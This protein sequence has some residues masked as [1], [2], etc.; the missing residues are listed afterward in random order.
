MTKNSD[1]NASS[2]F[3]RPNKKVDNANK[4]SKQTLDDSIHANKNWADSTELEFYHNRLENDGPKLDQIMNKLE[5]ITTQL[6]T[7]HT[8][9]SFT[10]ERVNTIEENLGIT[11]L[12]QTEADDLNASPLMTDDEYQ[13]SDPYKAGIISD[14]TEVDRLRD[15]NETLRENLE[16]N[17]KK[18]NYA[19]QAVAQMQRALK[20]TNVITD[21]I[22]VEA[23][24][25]PSTNCR[26]DDN[27]FVSPPPH[28]F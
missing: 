23:L 19:L 15:E 6:T 3:H 2:N 14:Y 13:N 11:A 20:N 10:I 12:T 8:D 7:I 28:Y 5:Q 25:T 27:T 4:D 9:L 17:V 21:V 22:P 1:P 16:M 24:V 26:N 18:L